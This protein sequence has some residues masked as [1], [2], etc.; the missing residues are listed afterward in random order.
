MKKSK[1][2]PN[3]VN[4]YTDPDPRQA[5]FFSAYFDPKSDTFGNATQSALAAKYSRDY[6]ENIT[7]LMPEWLS[8]KI[9]EM[10]MLS[11]AE[12]NLSEMLDF[13]PNVQAMGAF[14]PLFEKKKVKK[15]VRGKT[16]TVTEQGKP[17]MV[18]NSK[19]LQIKMDV[20]KFVAER[21]GKIKYGR[22]PAT[23]AT[24]PVQAVQVNIND[25]RK[26]FA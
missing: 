16:R 1:N 15:K 3:K 23:K 21:V 24:P 14:G 7:S 13:S 5:F 11:R 22:E 6:A 2:N 25:D 26:S 12:R 20:S 9:G 17:I 19:L 18:T 4:Q 10:D 8:A